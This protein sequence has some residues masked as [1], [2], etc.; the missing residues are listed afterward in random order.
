[1]RGGLVPV[2][3][4][5]GCLETAAEITAD[6]NERMRWPSTRGFLV[7]RLER[8]VSGLAVE[9]RQGLQASR[10]TFLGSHLEEGP[11]EA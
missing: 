6:H 9:D 1:M 7:R 11:D 10:G 5:G 8:K 3:E 4:K 2:E